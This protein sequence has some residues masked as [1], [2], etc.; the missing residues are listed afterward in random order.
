MPTTV[1]ETGK[2]NAAAGLG[3]FGGVFTPSILTILG[4]IMYLR[5]GWV[6]GNA[7]LR[8]TL[9]I[10]TIATAI[11]FLTALSI[12]QI[13]TDQRVKTGG[14]YYMISRSLGVEVGG[15]IGLPL[16]FAQALSVALY[17]IGFAESLHAVFPATNQKLV[18]AIT[19]TLVTVLALVSAR[20]A[21]KAQ[22]F[23]MA[24]IA[25]SL[26]SL[27]LGEPLP[28]A[29]VPLPAA[30]PVGFW[31]VFAVFFPAVTGIM[32]GVN[33]SGDLAD[34]RR[35]IPRGTLAAVGVSYLVYMTI[36]FLLARSAD[37]ATLIS[38][39]LVMRRIALSGNAILVGVW[40][41]TLSSALGSI[42]GAPRILQALARDRIL[43]RPLRFLGW[44]TEDGDE[45]RIGTLV[46]FAIA[47]IAISLGDLN[48]IAPILTMF[49]LAT[50]AV[51]N[52]VSSV[53][54]F[55]RNPSFRPTFHVHWGL[56]LLGAVGCSSVMFLINPLATILAGITMLAIYVWLRSRGLKATWGDLRQGAWQAIIRW[57]L[58]NLRSSGHAKAWRPN[59]L[60]LA[61]SPAKRWYLIELAN[62][63][64]HDRGILSIATILPASTTS[65]RKHQL[66]L[67][68][69]EH[70]EERSVEALVRVVSAESPYKG[71]GLL[72]E[73]YGLGSLVPNTIMLGDG[74]TTKDKA[75]YASMVARIHEANRNVV[76]V[77]APE[78]Y[79]FGARKRIDVWLHGLRGNGSLMLTLAH[80]LAT[81]LE[82]RHS[83]IYL[84]MIVKNREGAEDARTNLVAL[85]DT[86]RIAADVEVIVDERPALSVIAEVSRRSDIAFLGLPTP[87]EDDHTAFAATLAE[88]QSKTSAIPAVAFLLA[89]S[90]GELQHILE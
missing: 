61:G 42:L 87:N 29:A 88:L 35:S 26:I 2:P 5:F 1:L 72:V 7:G 64:S 85:I 63:I 81:S 6:V 79:T 27:F 8:G 49:F 13:A 32:A 43:P 3:T 37:T 36:P 59:V 66:A 28:A 31:L 34:P 62:T 11:T 25:I 74:E 39:P 70:L 78:S 16:Y 71:A 83:K 89:S 82:W 55:L 77:R 65:A 44:G 68:I 10:V 22:Y 54:R 73:A 18:A 76:I 75:E 84:R 52:V 4:V 33:M 20:A 48:V 17:T 58:L 19:A 30:E 23:I 69:R 12:A 38:D 15:A 45:P 24:G 9:I 40:G 41:A 57:G 60:V 50:Y 47:L 21:I 80:L 53:E 56:S 86:A 14:A 67:T 46:S 90:D 51:I